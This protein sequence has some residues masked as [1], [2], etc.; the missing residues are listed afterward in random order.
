M[1]RSIPHELRDWIELVV[2]DNANDVLRYLARRTTQ[3]EDAADLLGHVLLALWENGASIPT[4]D[5]EA[6]MWCFGIARNV[7]R[8]HYRRTSKH[9]ALADQLRDHLRSFA[10]DDSADITAETR[11]RA[12][13]VRHAVGSLDDCSRELVVMV[14]WDGFTIAEAARLLSMNESSARTRH[15]RALQRLRKELGDNI[16]TAIW[17]ETAPRLT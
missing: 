14:H 8:E 12:E 11:M 10:H 1:Y 7:L 5:T 2:A 17:V 4:S 16:Q 6:R 9:L 13:Q 15:A 3:A